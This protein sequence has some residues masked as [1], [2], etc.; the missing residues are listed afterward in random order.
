MN[1]TITPKAPCPVCGKR[2]RAGSKPLAACTA[3]L[4]EA[5]ATPEAPRATEAPK[6]ASASLYNPSMTTTEA[7]TAPRANGLRLLLAARKSRKATDGDTAAMYE[8]QDHRAEQWADRTGHAIVAR[9][10]DTKS[11]TSAPW[12]RKQLRPWMTDP[13]KMARFDAILISDTDRLSRGTDEDFHWIENWCYRTGK[14]IMVADGPQFPP[15]EGP[16]GEVTVTTG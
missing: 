10:A 16:M 3:K 15:R 5:Q 7:H 6:A 8:R 14:S 1:A 2:H 11:G 9:T 4:V 12:E 13:A